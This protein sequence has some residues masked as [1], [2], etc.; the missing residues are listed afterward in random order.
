MMIS[1]EG[2]RKELE[3]KTIEELI[4]KRTKLFNE[5]VEYENRHIM[6]NEEYSEEE[7][8]KPSPETVY[9]MNNLYLKEVTDLLLE[10]NKN[11]LLNNL[12]SELE[13]KHNE[14]KFE[15][16]HLKYTVFHWMSGAIANGDAIETSIEIGPEMFGDKWKL[17]VIHKYILE[18]D[19]NGKSIKEQYDLNNQDEIIKLLENNDLRNLKNNYFSND[20]IQRYS[21]WELEYNN[22]FK[23]SGTFDNQPEQIKNIVNILDCEKIIQD[24]LSKVKIMRE[25]NEL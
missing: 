1:P 4:V 18:S 13:H 8:V 3:N 21:H 25:N 16:V 9:N 23:I 11:N 7:I 22:Y 2:F 12:N 6:N 19:F 10:K 24:I 5:L 15:L 17:N 14:E 20:K